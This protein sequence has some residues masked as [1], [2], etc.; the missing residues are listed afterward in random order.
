[1]ANN[2][3][4]GNNFASVGNCFVDLYLANIGFRKVPIDSP[5][6]REMLLKEVAILK[7]DREETKKDFDIQIKICDEEI[8]SR[9]DAILKARQEQSL[10]QCE[11]EEINRQVISRNSKILDQEKQIDI[12][13]KEILRLQNLLETERE[14]TKQWLAKLEQTNIH[15]QTKLNKRTTAINYLQGKLNEKQDLFINFLRSIQQ[16]VKFPGEMN[17]STLTGS[18]LQAISTNIQSMSISL[19]QNKN[20]LERLQKFKNTVAKAIDLTATL[21]G[22]K[23]SILKNTLG[24]NE[25]FVGM[26]IDP[27]FICK[28]VGCK[29]KFKFL[30]DL[31]RHMKRTHH[32]Q[33]PLYRWTTG[34]KFCGE[35]FRHYSA[36]LHHRKLSW[37]VIII[38]AVYILIVIF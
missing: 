13:N 4:M 8:R 34:C 14:N 20:E 37:Y 27:K 1:M 22:G 2:T 24:S 6:E 33:N 26:D 3:E 18:N 36:L 19:N 21:K 38:I 5:T 31:K 16:T 17:P 35:K 32:V 15:Q 28:R 12:Q 7:K 11:I 25:A 23:G 30:S 29:A 10:K 9:D